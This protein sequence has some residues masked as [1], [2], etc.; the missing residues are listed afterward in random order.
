MRPVLGDEVVEI[1]LRDLSLALRVV[2]VH[3]AR[4]LARGRKHVDVRQH[5]GELARRDV[6][7][8]REALQLRLDSVQVCLLH[9]R[10]LARDLVHR[11]D[12]LLERI[13]HL[14]E[15]VVGERDEG[16]ELL[17][18]DRIGAVHV[19]PVEE[20]VALPAL[21]VESDLVEQ[22]GEL[23]LGE[24][25]AAVLV[26]L[27]EQRRDVGSAQLRVAALLAHGTLERFLAHGL[28]L[29]GRPLDVPPRGLVDLG[30]ARHVRAEPQEHVGAHRALVQVA[31]DAH[32]SGPVIALPARAVRDAPDLIGSQI[33]RVV[34]HALLADGRLN[35]DELLGARLVGVGR[36]AHPQI[37][38]LADRA[39]VQVLAKARVPGDGERRLR[40]A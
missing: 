21:E 12:P 13:A 5:D 7:R 37:L 2:E 19:H 31:V 33:H 27:V 34:L 4:E 40:R 3:D 20:Q 30:R 6:G 32:E 39:A 38:R 28:A 16:E 8:R 22:L 18:M 1:E 15:L 9:T 10:R 23:R 25:A 35:L 24:L 11:A 17:L 36:A 14:V 26:V 29:V